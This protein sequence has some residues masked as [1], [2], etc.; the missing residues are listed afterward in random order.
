MTGQLCQR[1]SEGTLTGLGTQE[2]Q[3]A[4]VTPDPGGRDRVLG[5]RQG[6]YKKPA[7]KG[8]RPGGDGERESPAGEPAPPGGA[9]GPHGAPGVR[10]TLSGTSCPQGPLTRGGGLGAL[11]GSPASA[12]QR[13]GSRPL[14]LRFLEGCGTPLH[15][16][17]S[18]GPEHRALQV[19]SKLTL[20]PPWPFAR[21]PTNP[22]IPSRGRGRVWC[23]QMDTTEP[24][25]PA[26]T[27]TPKAHGG[28][29]PGTAPR[30]LQ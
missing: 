13:A 17:N 22:V 27:S 7:P 15:A 3:T 5:T 25:L 12:L 2:L 8:W 26:S 30:R 29:D 11:R 9:Q 16:P 19:V 23:G 4:P 6:L 14:G 28:G 1:R 10:A 20:P 21:V 24:P 18:K